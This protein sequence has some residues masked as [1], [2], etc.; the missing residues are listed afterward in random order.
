MTLPG[1]AIAVHLLAVLWWIGGLAFVTLVFLPALRADNT[2]DRH[3][4]LQAIEHRFAPQARIAIVLVGL[5][6]G[7]LLW[8]LGAWH[9]LNLAQFWWLSAM[10]AYWLLFVIILFVVEPLGLLQRAAFATHDPAAGWRRFHA[11]HATLLGL[12]VIIIA[13]AVAGSHGF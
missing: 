11:V 8:E 5:S 7:Y 1:I 13:G 12:A 2:R 4:L 3:A 6:G 10:I 9:W